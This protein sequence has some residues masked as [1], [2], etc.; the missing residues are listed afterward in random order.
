MKIFPNPAK[1]VISVEIKSK[2]QE[3]TSLTVVDHSGQTVHQ[4]MVKLENG[5]NKFVVNINHLESGR[6]ELYFPPLNSQKFVKL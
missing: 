1:D 2:T 4:I 5:F 3:L 6:Y